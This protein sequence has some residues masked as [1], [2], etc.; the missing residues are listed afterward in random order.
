MDL[1]KKQNILGSSGLTFGHTLIEWYAQGFTVFLPKLS[2]AMGLNRTQ[3]GLIVSV[4][5]FLAALS[6]PFL[7]IFS[8]IIGRRTSA[9]ALMVVWVVVGYLA[10]SLAPGYLWIVVLVALAELGSVAWHPPAMAIMADQFPEKKGLAISIHSLGGAVAGAIAPVCMGFLLVHLSWRAALQVV[11]APILLLTLPLWFLLKNVRSATSSTTSTSELF[12]EISRMKTN[13]SLIGI[14]FVAGSNA[15]IRNALISMVPLYLA[16]S[17]NMNIG[18]IGIHM[19]M[20]TLSGVIATPIMGM[21]SDKYGRKPVLATGMAFMGVA[22]IVMAT[23]TAAGT[24]L[25]LS[26]L[27]VGFFN[28]SLEPVH[29]ATISDLTRRD[30]T[31]T[32]MGILMASSGL[33][34]AI[35][36]VLVGLTADTK[37]FQ[38]AFVFVAVISFCAAGVAMFLRIPQ[39]AKIKFDRESQGSI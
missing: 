24:G 39:T 18:L 34:G 2:A 27:S 3:V 30:V 37:G 6:S 31:A 38:I 19:G 1:S 16:Y 7:G 20:L 28:Q 23:Q 35:S 36:P 29:A 22:I 26:L 13:P 33:M 10:V 25:I 12:Q 9:M 4:N 5:Y 11:A 32:A 14:L 15:M 17:L 8:D 21:F